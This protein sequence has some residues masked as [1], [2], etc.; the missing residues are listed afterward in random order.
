M[1][2]TEMMQSYDLELMRKPDV[3]RV[4]SK[5]KVTFYHY[6]T[7]ATTVNP[8]T[9]KPIS[10]QGLWKQKRMALEKQLATTKFRTDPRGVL[11]HCPAWEE[12]PPVLRT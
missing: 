2:N 8:R 7:K 5:D 9:E 1:E 6:T 4:D 10:R 12:L 11:T 3:V